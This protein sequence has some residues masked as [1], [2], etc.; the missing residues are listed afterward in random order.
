MYNIT[1]YKHK[2]RRHPLAAEVGLLQ[3]KT[4]HVL[5]LLL[6]LLQF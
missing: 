3:C 6:L 5:L 4:M 2:P 1:K